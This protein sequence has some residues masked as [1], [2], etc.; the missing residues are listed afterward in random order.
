MFLLGFST[1]FSTD[2][3]GLSPV[4][5]PEAEVPALSP[6]NTN[7]FIGDDELMTLDI[8][9]LNRRVKY[10]PKAIVREIKHRR[11]TLKNRGYARWCRV[12]KID[13]TSSLQKSYTDLEKERASASVNLELEVM[14]MQSVTNGSVNMN[15]YY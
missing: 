13:E 4:S 15:N 12:K 1:E 14:M 3:E 8:K 6:I 5:S 7:E 10:L 2:F 11:R 9:D